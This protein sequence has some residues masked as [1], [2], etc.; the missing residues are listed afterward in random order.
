MIPLRDNVHSRHFPYITVGLIIINFYTFFQEIGMSDAA[1]AG[2]IQNYGLVP[3]S[4]LANFASHPLAVSTYVPLFS[5]L[6]LHGG[7]MHIIGNMWYLW[8][9]GHSVED[10]LGRL[11]F[12]WFYLL[13]GIA[14]NLSQIIVDPA[15]TVPTIGASGAISGV[16]GAYFLLYPR[17][18]ISTLIPL[19]IFFPII[20]IRA[21]LFLIFWFLLQLQ[22]GALALFTAGSGIAWWA[23]IG[24]FVAGMALVKMVKD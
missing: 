4:F 9:F 12:T 21:W 23:H 10:C 13:C 2:S 6:F 3:A 16:L 17:A 11:N 20:Q 7:W 14:A 15:S 24:G 22:S 19:F 5:D 8:L 18:R 1:L